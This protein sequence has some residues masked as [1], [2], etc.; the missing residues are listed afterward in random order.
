MVERVFFY[1]YFLFT[2][3][4]HKKQTEH[5]IQDMMFRNNLIYVCP[6]VDNVKFKALCKTLIYLNKNVL[7]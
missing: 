5:T 1:E 7:V 3:I 4:T 2:R 6:L